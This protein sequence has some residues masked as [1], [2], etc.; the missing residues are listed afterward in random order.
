MPKRGA[1][2]DHDRDADG[3][4]VCKAGIKGVVIK[5]EVSPG[6]PTGIELPPLPYTPLAPV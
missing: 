3:N 5:G 2:P 4:L 1:V 6:D